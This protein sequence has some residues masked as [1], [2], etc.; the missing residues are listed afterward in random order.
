MREFV[1]LKFVMGDTPELQGYL[2]VYFCECSKFSSPYQVLFAGWLEAQT[3]FP[4]LAVDV[5]ALK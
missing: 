3:W 1:L 4:K 2:H 5:N